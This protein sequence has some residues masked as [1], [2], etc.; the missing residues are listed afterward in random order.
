MCL[1]WS[2]WISLNNLVSIINIHTRMC[3]VSNL[4][5]SSSKW[6]PKFVRSII[7]AAISVMKSHI[8]FWKFAAR[9][10]GKSVLLS[11]QRYTCMQNITFQTA[12][13]GIL[14]L[15]SKELL[16][17]WLD[18]C[19]QEKKKDEP[20]VLKLTSISICPT[21]RN[22]ICIIST[23]KP[24]FSEWSSENDWLTEWILNGNIYLP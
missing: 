23:K 10:N 1:K 15:K 5:F 19:L 18:A 24:K 6:C 12:T 16:Y 13:T 9:W 7:I 22:H 21:R 2:L 20:F 4:T 3:I 14:F 17:M 11:I 8:N